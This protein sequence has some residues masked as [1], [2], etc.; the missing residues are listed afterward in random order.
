MLHIETGTEIGVETGSHAACWLPSVVV[1]TVAPANQAP[2]FTATSLNAVFQHQWTAPVSVVTDAV[3]SDTDSD[4]YNGGTW[5]VST[6][7][8]DPTDHLFFAGAY[9][10]FVS[11]GAA[12]GMGVLGDGAED[13]CG[14]L[15]LAECER[16]YDSVA[17]ALEGD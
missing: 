6:D 8:N 4:N 14:A 13:E 5:S 3:V 12:A 11:S 15:A 1:T 7:H 10:G 16:G 9:L 17:I 2:T